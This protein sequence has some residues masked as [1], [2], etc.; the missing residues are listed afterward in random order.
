MNYIRVVKDEFNSSH[1][2]LVMA[3]MQ[4]VDE[5]DT[6]GIK[7]VYDEVVTAI[8]VAKNNG[9]E[10]VSCS[11]STSQSTIVNVLELCDFNL[12]DTL[13]TYEFKRGDSMLYTTASHS[14]EIGDCLD[15]DVD[16]LCKLAKQVYQIDRYH[17]DKSLNAE[18]CDSYYEKWTKNCIDTNLADRVIVAHIN[19]HP[20][21]YMPI[22]IYPENKE[23]RM[24]LS[25]VSAAHRRLGIFTSMSYECVRFMLEDCK[26]RA[27]KVLA[28][29]YIDNIAVQKA[30]IR[31]GYTLYGS[32]YIFQKKL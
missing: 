25:A 14:V 8:K 26:N 28:G 27:D 32:K 17:K 15:T 1:F 2:G 7:Q 16:E 4:I 29:T 22:K 13:I 31:L 20:V 5:L 23:V 30:W 24:I 11:I 21:G 10:H 6:F 19:G 9:I 12:I 3:N 18:L